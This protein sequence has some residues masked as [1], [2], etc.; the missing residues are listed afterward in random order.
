MTAASLLPGT[1]TSGG[2]TMSA[3]VIAPVV[4]VEAVDAEKEPWEGVTVKETDVE[5][6]AP[7][8]DTVVESWEPRNWIPTVACQSGFH[9]G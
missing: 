4:D 5:P 3:G 7:P 6:D 9:P 2:T 1:G 8:A